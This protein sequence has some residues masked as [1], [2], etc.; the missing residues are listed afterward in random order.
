V[1]K[2]ELSGNSNYAGS[3]KSASLRPATNNL[4]IVLEEEE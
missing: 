1:L 3:S 2:R 4:H